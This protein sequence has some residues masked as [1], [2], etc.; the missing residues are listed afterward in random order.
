[1]YTRRNYEEQ[2]NQIQ[3]TMYLR[4]IEQEVKGLM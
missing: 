1:M 3:N 2:T 4:D